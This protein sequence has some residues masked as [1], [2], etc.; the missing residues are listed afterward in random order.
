V[1]VFYSHKT[2]SKAADFGSSQ[3][4]IADADLVMRFEQVV[5]VGNADNFSEVHVASIFSAVI[6]R[7][8]G[9]SH[10]YIYMYK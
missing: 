10:I 9:C 6:R 8:S 7:M 4:L 1:T 2:F 5:E 3:L